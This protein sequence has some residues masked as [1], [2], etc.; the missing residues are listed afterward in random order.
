MTIKYPPTIEIDY[1]DATFFMH[2]VK[3]F[4]DENKLTDSHYLNN[5]YKSLNKKVEVNC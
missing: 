3:L 5:L 1:N 2:L 4:I